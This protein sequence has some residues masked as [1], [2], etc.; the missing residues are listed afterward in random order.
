MSEDRSTISPWGHNPLAELRLQDYADIARRRKWWIIL[1]AAGILVTTIVAAFRLPNVYHSE[2]TILVDPQQVPSN[3]VASTVT[4]SVMDRLSTIRQELL[5][6]TRLKELVKRLDLYRDFVKQGKEEQL[7]AKLQRSI[8][9]EVVDAGG[10]R[11]SAFKIGYTGRTA[12]ESAQVAN[13]LAATVI[14]EN[15]KAREQQFSGTAEFLDSELQDTKKQLETTEA[16]LGRI[17]STY[18]MDL[19]ESKQFH[20]EALS[21]LRNQL[22]VSQDKVAAAQQQKVYL[23]SLLVSSSPAVDLDANGGT[24]SSPEQAQMDKLETQLATLRAR[25]GPGHP[26]VRKTQVQLNQLKAKIAAEQASEAAESTSKAAPRT[27]KNPVVE[28][29]IAKLDQQIADETKTQPQLAEQINFHSSKLEQEPIF[30]QKIGGLMRDYDT[31][32]AHYNTLLDKK[33]SAEMAT[34]LDER[35]KGERFVILDTAQVPSAPTGPHRAMLIFA[36]LFGGLLGGLGLAMAVEFADQSVRTERDA[37]R[38]LK[39][40]VLAEIPYVATDQHL[41]TARLRIAGAFAITLVCATGLGFII[42]HYAE[43]FL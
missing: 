4:T 13:E 34:E 17:K 39:K 27:L 5:S 8:T 31:L 38:I 9:I 16:E 36:G 19:P 35:Q 2:T 29:E 12:A 25:Y 43:R 10:Q 22:R 33:L 7:V 20:L 30:E 24:S 32:R 11:L 18:I 6:P 15:L 37:A 41:R 42:S 28:A 14:S 3:Y 1:T 21:T 26:D 40:G 23:Q